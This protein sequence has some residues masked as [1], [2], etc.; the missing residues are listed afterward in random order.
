MNDIILAIVREFN[1]WLAIALIGLGIAIATAR[2]NK[3][4]ARRADDAD[5]RRHEERMYELSTER[6]VKLDRLSSHPDEHKGPK[7]EHRISDRDEG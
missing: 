4:W 1:V 7:I 5:I 2:V 3:F 6:S